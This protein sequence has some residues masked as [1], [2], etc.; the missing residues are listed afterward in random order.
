[1]GPLLGRGGFGSVY[2][3]V[4]LCDNT[5]VR[6]GAGGGAGR[7][8]GQ[9][10]LSPALLSACRCP[11]NGVT[12]TLQRSGSRIPMEIAMMRKV[13]SDCS[14]IIQLLHWFELPDSFLLVLERPEPSQ[15]LFELIRNRTFVPE[16]PA[17]GI[18]LQVLRAVQHC[19]SRGVLH[20]D[21]KSNNIIIHLVTGKVKL[22]DFGCST[23]LRNMVYTKFSGERTAQGASSSRQFGK[24]VTCW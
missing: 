1:M 3:G 9:A 10:R 19:H 8:R 13:R 4:R 5:P 2:S 11:A 23:L 6:G 24:R 18:F 20:R 22:I 15:D 14:T 21:I 7:R 16:S 17:Q 12:V